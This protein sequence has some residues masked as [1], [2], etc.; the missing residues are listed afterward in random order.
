MGSW[1]RHLLTFQ[2]APQDMVAT[3]NRRAIQFADQQ[4]YAASRGEAEAALAVRAA[5]SQAGEPVGPRPLNM[6][7]VT[8][9][10]RRI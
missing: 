7:F 8:E 2:E 9:P 6:H 3:A 5:L 4:V 1:H 10:D